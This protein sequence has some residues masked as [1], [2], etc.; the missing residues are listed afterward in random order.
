MREREPTSD[1][2]LLSKTSYNEGVLT[3]HQVLRFWRSQEPACYPM[4]SYASKSIKCVNTRI[5]LKI[6]LGERTV[7]GEYCPVR[8][9]T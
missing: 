8:L 5:L 1:N 6:T 2:I 7:V 9:V 3:L 4:L